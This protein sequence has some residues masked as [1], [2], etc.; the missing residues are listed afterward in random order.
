M[1]EFLGKKYAISFPPS[2]QKKN[3]E[4][5]F[6]PLLTLGGNCEKYTPPLRCT[7]GSTPESLFGWVILY[8]AQCSLY[9]SAWDPFNFDP[10]PGSAFQKKWILVQISFHT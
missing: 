8:T 3:H 2:P 4:K 7:Q 9:S 10:D 6:P 1:N 5:S